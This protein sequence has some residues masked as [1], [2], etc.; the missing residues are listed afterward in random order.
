MG[1]DIVRLWSTRGFIPAFWLTWLDLWVM[2]PPRLGIEMMILGGKHLVHHPSTEILSLLASVVTILSCFSSNC[3]GDFFSTLVNGVSSLAQT[4]LLAIPRGW[5]L[6]IFLIK[7]HLYLTF[8]NPDII[9]IL[10]ITISI[11]SSWADN[12]QVFFFSRGNCQ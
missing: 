11:F 10:L 3:S 2:L 7:H 6:A 12:S 9:S 5:T 4:F 1:A 8:F